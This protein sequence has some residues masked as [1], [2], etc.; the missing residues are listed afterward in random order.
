MSAPALYLAQDENLA[1]ARIALLTE[2][3]AAI[4]ALQR[5]DGHAKGLI[6]ADEEFRDGCDGRHIRADIDDALR[7]TRAAYAV[8]HMI[9]DKERP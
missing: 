7:L 2:L 8:V 5:A 4:N 6:E 9:A 3:T 1:I